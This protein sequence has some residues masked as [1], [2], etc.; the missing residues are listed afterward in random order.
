M[1]GEN[2][3]G[4]VRPGLKEYIE[5]GYPCL[6]LPT[7]EPMVATKRIIEAL[8]QV[9]DI[10]GK[11]MSGIP[12]GVWKINTGLYVGQ[13]GDPTKLVKANYGEDMMDALSSMMQFN[14][15]PKQRAPMMYVFHNIRELIK[16]T[17]IIQQMVDTILVG[18]TYGSCVFIIG[19]FLDIPPELR[20][21]IQVVDCPLPTREQIQEDYRRIV[22]VYE[23]EMDL[24]EGE[25]LDTLLR[26]AS[27]AA[28]GLDSIGAENALALSM[29]AV[30]NIDLRV[31]QS[32][33]EQEVKKSDVLEFIPIDVKMD[34]VGGFSAFKDWLKRREKVFSDE[35]REFGLPFPKG[36]LIV[37]VGGTGKSLV[38]KAVARYLGIPCLRLDMGRVARSLYG[39]SEAAIRMALQVAEAV[40]PIVLWIDEIDKGFAGMST[41]G[42]LDSGV[43]SRVIQTFLTWRQET[44]A[45]VFIAATANET[46]NLPSM[47]YRKGRFDE[48]W[49][50]SLPDL[51]EREEIFSIHIKK[52]ERKGN[53]LNVKKF[54]L[55]SL[56]KKAKDFTGA[57]IESCIEDA[58]FTAFDNRKEV[59]TDLVMRAIGETVPQATR[60]RAEIDRIE[61]WVKTHARLVSGQDF[62][63]RQRMGFEAP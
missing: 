9:G 32:Q 57:E 48:V 31:I 15:E 23:E 16:N 35:A 20:S 56:A 14:K 44:K 22:K 51:E 1:S 18:R 43:T 58:M 40:A 60:D 34:D 4:E 5:A 49:A 30:G 27:T 26:S 53:G 11:P 19:A 63:E 45:P 47:V 33:K 2:G 28:V 62:E 6:F 24:P 54:D 37:G 46:T 3:N 38:A 42:S 59:T 10:R 8:D 39:E 36:V 41:S 7:V 61:G 52:R 17:G 25:A 55:Q 21:L 29:A 13:C 12:F 50:T